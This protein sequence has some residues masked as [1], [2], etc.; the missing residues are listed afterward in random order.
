[1]QR[2]SPIHAYVFT[3]TLPVFL[4]A[5]LFSSSFA[6]PAQ[7]C[8][9]NVLLIESDD[10][11]PDTIHALGNGIIQTPNLDKLVRRGLTF[12]RA[13]SPNPICTPSRAETMTGCNSFRNGILAFAGRMQPDLVLWADT[14]RKAGYHTWYVGKW[15]ND[16]V[17]TARGY[18]QSLGLY[19]GGGAKY[20]M[21]LD[22]DYRGAT[23]TGYRNWIFQTDDGQLMPERGVGLTPDISR[24]F[25]D[26]AIEFLRR[27]PQKPF[28]LHLNFTAPHDPLLMPPGYEGRYD[29]HK[30]PLP[31]NYLP[32]HP[33]DHGNFDGRDEQL[34]P[35][36][37]TPEIVR[38]DLAVYYSVISHMDEHIGR[39]FQTLEDTGQQDTTIVIFISDQGLA[40]GS[41]G[42]R[43]K[44]NMYD[45]TVG[46]P[47]VLAG[48]GIP[49][50]RRLNAQCYLRDLYPTVCEMSGVAVPKTVQGRSLAPVIR[51]EKD[52]V[53]PFTVGYYGDTQRMIR[54]DRWKLIHYPKAGKLQLFDL[55]ADP[56]ETKNL[57]E[58][59]RFRA[60]VEEL[61]AKL[62]AWLKEA[63]DP[64]AASGG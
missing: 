11:R 56:H 13:V 27:K 57:A 26:A 4:L 33:F 9:W 50:D 21:A 35:W 7:S 6:E 49:S 19:R 10:Q 24:H 58:D 51:G 44:Q 48:P 38:K 40:L 25:A 1:M 14:M 36:P 41:H 15:H 47:M 34:L 16:G 37:R 52:S 54:T 22:V 28:F 3:L 39:I 59:P 2:R 5:A 42:L 64:L 17:P 29:P 62:H 30:I 12:T 20:P 45:H 53:Y 46:T 32:E 61:R 8:R 18:E 63:G 23:V 55:Q 43:G 31:P 60:T